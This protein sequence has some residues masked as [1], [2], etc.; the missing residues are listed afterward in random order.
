MCYYLNAF[1]DV[2]YV[3]FKNGNLSKSDTARLKKAAK[4]LYY[5]VLELSRKR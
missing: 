5:C 1:S 3:R 4:R 2:L